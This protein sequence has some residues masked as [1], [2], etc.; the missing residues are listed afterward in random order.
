MVIKEVL[1]MKKV[2]VIV[3]VYNVDKYLDKCLDS[4]VNQTLKDIEIIIVNDGSKDDSE[5]IIK[6]Y[7]KKY[8]EIIKAYKKSNGGLSDARNYGLK[9]ASGNYIAFVD[10]D[11]YVDINMFSKM[12][13]YAKE[14]KLDIV[15][16][17]TMMQ[18]ENNTYALKSNLG[19]SFDM[20]KNYI[21]SYPMACIRLVKS[22]LM[23]KHKFEKGIL[24]EDLNLMPILALDTEKIGFLEEPLYYYVIRSGSIMQQKEFSLKL[25]DIFKVL[26]KICIQNIKMKLNI[27]ILLIY[28]AVLL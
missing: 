18:E 12:Y 28:F 20:V 23:K 21:I 7:Q 27:Y 15:V 6:K 25:L 16:C 24:Y 9:Y 2:S 4:L 5:K 17:D 13:N 19:Y 22:S 10:G 8:P 11:D 1:Y 3:P 26:E 14:N